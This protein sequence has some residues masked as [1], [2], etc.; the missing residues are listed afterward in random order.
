MYIGSTC[1]GR[2]NGLW[3]NWDGQHPRYTYERCKKWFK[4]WLELAK[5]NLHYDLP[6]DS[7]DGTRI[8]DLINNIGAIIFKVITD[9]RKPKQ[10]K[11][12]NKKEYLTSY[13]KLKEITNM[14]IV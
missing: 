9:G 5:C 1:G 6:K 14:T 13:Q 11:H 3:S 7:W 12:C 2:H 8:S 4:S 10:I